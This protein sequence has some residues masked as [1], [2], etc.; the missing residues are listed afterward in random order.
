[1]TEGQRSFSMSDANRYWYAIYTKPRWEKKIARILSDKGIENYCP[2][3]RTLKQWSDRKKVVYE[4]VF[5]SYIFVRVSEPDKWGLKKIEGIVN[6]VYWLGKPAVIKESEILTIKKFLNDFS[7]VS[8]EQYRV[9]INDKVVITQGILM[10]ME[11]NVLEISGKK[12]RIQIQSLGC[13]LTAEIEMSKLSL[14]NEHDLFSSN[15]LVIE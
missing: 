10:N 3:T 2:L 6:F 4:P 14:L 7:N 11:G 15:C 12:A 8:V 1:M 13:F 5:K 9:N